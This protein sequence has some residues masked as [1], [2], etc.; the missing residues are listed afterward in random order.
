MTSYRDGAVSGEQEPCDACTSSADAIT[1]MSASLQAGQKALKDAKHA[2]TQ[3]SESL[4]AGQQALHA[5]E[6]AMKQITLPIPNDVAVAMGYQPVDMTTVPD[7]IKDFCTNNCFFLLKA[8]NRRVH[9]RAV[10]RHVVGLAL[11]GNSI[12]SVPNAASVHGTPAQVTHTVIPPTTVPIGKLNDASFSSFNESTPLSMLTTPP[13]T[14]PLGKLDDTS[15]TSF[16]EH[17]PLSSFTVA[18]PANNDIRSEDSDSF[19]SFRL[20][21]RLRV[22]SVSSSEGSTDWEREYSIDKS[23][24]AN[25]TVPT[26]PGS[27]VDKSEM[28]DVVP[29]P[30]GSVAEDTS[31]NLP[32]PTEPQTSTDVPPE[33]RCNT[34]TDNTIGI[35]G[36][37]MQRCKSESHGH[38]LLEQAVRDKK[39]A[40]VTCVLEK[41]YLTPADFTV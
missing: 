10:T 14:V 1:K 23:D 20:N 30:P 7:F 28:A 39:V 13:P 34:I 19:T 29:T 40:R 12:P 8:Q 25:V 4:E 11:A 27:V 17:T 36:S 16:N 6:T 22:I 5:A 32:A 37:S 3:L 18:A 35:S 15:F 24:M 9:S 33:S 21:E 38:A 41:T 2:I 26:P 31:V